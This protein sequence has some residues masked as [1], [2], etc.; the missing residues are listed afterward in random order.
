MQKQVR[1]E[2]DTSDTEKEKWNEVV[3]DLWDGKLPHLRE[4]IHNGAFVYNPQTGRYGF[5]EGSEY[6]SDE[7]LMND[8]MNEVEGEDH[9]PKGDAEENL[10]HGPD[11]HM[12][13]FSSHSLSYNQEF[14]NDG[15]FVYDPQTGRYGFQEGLEYDSEEELVDDF[16]DKEEDH[17]PK[18]GAE[19]SIVVI[20]EGQ[21]LSVKFSK[22]EKEEGTGHP[23]GPKSDEG[24]FDYNCALYQYYKPY[25]L[26]PFV[27]C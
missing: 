20:S 9:T 16:V 18:G 22:R 27:H 25:S 19:G 11:H 3:D 14:C 2:A 13:S 17:L 6:D 21:T 7:E 15:A 8:L 4:E 24:S 26:L 12:A 5:Q 23:G 10:G 1:A